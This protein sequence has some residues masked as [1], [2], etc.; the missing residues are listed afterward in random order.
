MSV[1]TEL[2]TNTDLSIIS[3][4]TIKDKIYIIREQQVMLDYD[5]ARIR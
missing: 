3:E 5:L 4:D 1:S 2:E